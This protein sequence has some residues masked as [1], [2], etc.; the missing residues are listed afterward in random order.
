MRVE[1]LKRTIKER[2]ERL[3]S[4]E[5]R[6]RGRVRAYTRMLDFV[7]QELADADKDLGKVVRWQDKGHDLL[8]QVDFMPTVRVLD[9]DSDAVLKAIKFATKA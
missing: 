9:T 2:I 7:D 6:H 8:S 3:E 4:R 1:E 5:S